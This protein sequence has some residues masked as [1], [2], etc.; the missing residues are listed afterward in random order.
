[1][2][3]LAFPGSSGM[4]VQAETPEPPASETA[5]APNRARRSVQDGWSGKERIPGSIHVSGV[6]PILLAD[7]AFAF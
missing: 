1:M 3:T 7:R 5:E 2:A 4:R 6:R